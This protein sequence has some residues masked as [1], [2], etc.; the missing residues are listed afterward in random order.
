MWDALACQ[1]PRLYCLYSRFF[2]YRGTA[3]G[4]IWNE[5]AQHD[6]LSNVGEKEIVKVAQYHTYL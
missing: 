5:M 4:Y 1:G 2:R 3:P 6:L